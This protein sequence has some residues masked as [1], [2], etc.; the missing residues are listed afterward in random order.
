MYTRNKNLMFGK[1]NPSYRTFLVIHIILSSFK[2]HNSSIQVIIFLAT[3]FSRLEGVVLISSR[4][5]AFRS[6]ILCIQWGETLALEVK[7][8][9]GNDE[10][11]QGGRV[12]FSTLL[13]LWQHWEV[14]F[15][16]AP[17]L[18]ARKHVQSLEISCCYLGPILHQRN[19]YRPTKA[20]GPEYD[21]LNGRIV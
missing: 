5:L 10:T 19:S 16:K 9:P 18:S 2:L 12:I 13:R 20:G 8:V 21:H 17:N 3:R 6:S 15:C 14:L 7:F 11:F 1:L 4:I